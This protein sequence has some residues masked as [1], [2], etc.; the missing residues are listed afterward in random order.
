MTQLRKFMA[1]SCTLIKRK[2]CPFCTEWFFAHS[3]KVH[4]GQRNAA[5]HIFP[6]HCSFVSLLFKYYVGWID[7]YPRRPLFWTYQERSFHH[8]RVWWLMG[9]MFIFPLFNLFGT[10]YCFRTASVKWLRKF[11]HLHY[12]CVP[13]YLDQVMLLNLFRNSWR[14]FLFQYQRIQNSDLIASFPSIYQLIGKPDNI[15]R[16][17][18]VVD[19]LMIW[20]Y[21][22]RCS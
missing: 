10:S 15:I 6:C 4:T 1:R 16:K 13:R 18:L 7:F 3:R 2:G 11:W 19:H 5:I 14:F 17:T 21:T 9:S 12:T 20:C 8:S 22:S